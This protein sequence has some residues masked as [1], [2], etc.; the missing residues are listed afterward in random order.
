LHDSQVHARWA[1]IAGAHVAAHA[2]PVRLHGGVLVVRAESGAWA[3]QLRYLAPR[4]VARAQ[5]V[6][7]SDRVTR[8]QIVS[9]DPG[10]RPQSD[11]GR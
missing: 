6:L 1:D 2:E 7:G 11:E 9:G 4:L 3:A 10:A 8:V 5:D